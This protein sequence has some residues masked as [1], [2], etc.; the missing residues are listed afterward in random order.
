MKARRVARAGSIALHLQ[1]ILFLGTP[2]QEGAHAA[3]RFVRNLV[4]SLYIN[5]SHIRDSTSDHFCAEIEQIETRFRSDLKGGYPRLQVVSFFEAK[6][7]KGRWVSE[8]F[9]EVVLLSNNDQVLSHADC[10][11]EPFKSVSLDADHEV[12]VTQLKHALTDHVQH[13]ALFDSPTESRYIRVVNELQTMIASIRRNELF[14]E[15]S[16]PHFGGPCRPGFHSLEAGSNRDT[17]PTSCSCSK[18]DLP[19]EEAF[20]W[21]LQ[22][23]RLKSWQNAESSNPLWLYGKPG[24]GKSTLTKFLLRKLEA[25]FVRER[26]TI[27]THFFFDGSQH[28]LGHATTRLL[29]SLLR[30]I[31]AKHADERGP[32]PQERQSQP[33]RLGRPFAFQM[34]RECLRQH[35]NRKLPSRSQIFL[36]LDGL[37]ACT[38]DEVS[39]ILDL[40]R[41]LADKGRSVV[42]KLLFTSRTGYFRVGDDD[43]TLDLDFENK[44]NAPMLPLHNIAHYLMPSKKDNQDRQ[45]LV[46]Q[47]Q[48]KSD[49]NFLWMSYIFSLLKITSNDNSEP[50]KQIA[51]LPPTMEETQRLLMRELSDRYDSTVRSIPNAAQMFCWIELAV[52]PLSSL[53][54]ETALSWIRHAK[55]SGTA[56]RRTATS[57]TEN[58]GRWPELVQRLSESTGGILKVVH[59]QRGSEVEFIHHSVKEFLLHPRLK[60]L[61]VPVSDMSKGRSI[62]HLEMARICLNYLSYTVSGV[63]KAEELSPEVLGQFP[64]L[65]YAASS[66]ISHAKAANSGS[67]SDEEF[68]RYFPWPTDPE[69]HLVHIASSIVHLDF[70]ATQED[71]WTFLHTAAYCGLDKPVK[72]FFERSVKHGVGLPQID[73][74]TSYRRTPLHLAVSMGHWSVVHLLLSGG[75][76]V[77]AKDAVYGNS[78]LHW[79]ALAPTTGSTERMVEYLIQAGADIKDDSNGIA[80]LVLASAYG[81]SAVVSTL[82]KAGADPDGMDRHRKLTALQLA[83]I[84]RNTSVVSMLL[85]ANARLNESHQRKPGQ[86]PLEVAV[87]TK[88]YEVIR[89]LL[90]HGATVSLSL[91]SFGLQHAVSP[92]NESERMWLDRMLLMFRGFVTA[93]YTQCP[94]ESVAGKGTKPSN[95]CTDKGDR[96]SRN[97]HKRSTRDDDS[98]QND[99]DNEDHPKR[100]RRSKIPPDKGIEDL[101][102]YCCPYYAR[103][104]SRFSPSCSK[105]RWTEGKLHHML[106]HL[107]EVHYISLC[108]R[109]KQIF[110]DDIK[111]AEHEKRPA[112]CVFIPQRNFEDGYD[113]RQSVRLHDRRRGSEKKLGAEAFYDLVSQ[114]LF[115]EQ[116][117]KVPSI[118]RA[119]EADVN[120]QRFERFIRRDIQESPWLRQRIFETIDAPGT[121]EEKRD[122]ILRHIREHPGSFCEKRKRKEETQHRPQSSGGEIPPLPSMDGLSSEAAPGVISTRDKDF[123]TALEDQ[124]MYSIPQSLSLQRRSGPWDNLDTMPLRDDWQMFVRPSPNFQ[125]SLTPAASNA[126]LN[127][128]QTQTHPPF[129]F[130]STQPPQQFQPQPGQLPSLPLQNS[131]PEYAD[132]GNA[133]SI[134]TPAYP[135]TGALHSTRYPPNPL[136]SDF[137]MQMPAMGQS[138]ND[139]D[140]IRRNQWQ[141]HREIDTA[142]V[143][144][145]QSNLASFGKPQTSATSTSRSEVP[146]EANQVALLS[147]LTKTGLGFEDPYLYSHYSE[148]GEL[149]DRIEFDE[150][151]SEIQEVANVPER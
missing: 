77:N 135:K 13:L 147:G 128:T 116:Y 39:D 140:Q 133:F 26:S 79:A 91:S 82:L 131:W 137:N 85:D 34:V 51:A 121:A 30:Q 110:P 15:K 145:S 62:I 142:T 61:C 101:E 141:A 105:R 75:A 106:Q 12:S 19:S 68:L 4:D 56:R 139:G 48:A 25:D 130:G 103:N 112:S 7:R 58:G 90:L 89:M 132:L 76:K 41:S 54:L 127:F 10:V 17:V 109:C 151:G 31:S 59:T 117:E 118:S 87:F 37:D 86:S 49:Y 80:P 144:D 84:H 81:Q 92:L 148:A 14:A 21:V 45:R 88:Q 29:A 57:Q 146:D 44:Y 55:D 78:V 98:Q 6:T 35:I 97:T 138:C 94:T 96:A 93:G 114:I 64:L 136:P 46:D 43:L 27:I 52:R 47:A 122:Q 5:R 60:E 69:M 143:S 149:L 28:H 111:L 63:R 104:Q 134:E 36:L 11:L 108:N 2:H 70:D 124:E 1:G 32:I 95:S 126:A 125:P 23:T 9:L 18:F 67:I 66:W 73:T 8:T 38:G 123:Q 113:M 42:L 150:A 102:S 22:D 20:S 50:L 120:S 107:R 115:E 72:A 40:S 16:G 100:Q 74:C 119:A 24:S 83:V 33:S 53:E 65:E 71:G 3:Q 99:D 129:T